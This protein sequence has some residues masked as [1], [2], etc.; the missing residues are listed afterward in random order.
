MGAALKLAHDSARAEKVEQNKGAPRRYELPRVLS[1]ELNGRHKKW[2]KAEL[3]RLRPRR[4][5]WRED[6]AGPLRFA[7]DTL[8]LDLTPEQQEVLA[9]M[10]ALSCGAYRGRFKPYG[11]ALKSGRGPGKTTLGAVLGLWKL[12][13]FDFSLVLGTS[14]KERQLF[15]VLWVK[16]KA[17]ID[18]SVVL[19]GLLDW[20]ATRIGVVGQ[21]EE[22]QA[23][24]RVAGQT[25]NIL[26]AH[27]P[28]FLVLVE[29]SSG[30]EDAKYDAV[31]A[32]LTERDNYIYAVGNTTRNVGWFY[33][34][35]HQDRAYWCTRTFTCRGN[36]L[37]D[38][39]TIER[40]EAQFGRG[41]MEVRVW[42]DGEFP[43][44]SDAAL[45]S[46]A[47]IRNAEDRAPYFDG[48]G[49]L[50][51]GIDPARFGSD[52]TGIVVSSGSDLVHGERVHGLRTTEVVGRVVA[53]ARRM[54]ELERKT[55]E[56]R[57]ERRRAQLHALGRHNDAEAVKV[58]RVYIRNVTCDEIGIGAG[59]VDDLIDAQ[60]IARE[61]REQSFPL[62]SASIVGLN[63][64]LPADDSD[65]F[66]R[67][68]DELWFALS[69]R[70][71][72]GRVAY[73][74]TFDADQRQR[75]AQELRPVEYGYSKTGRKRVDDKDKMRKKLK[76]SPDTADAVIHTFFSTYVGLLD[77]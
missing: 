65:Q 61:N 36:P 74:S 5:R 39:S 69:A 23:V 71:F 45:F 7:R 46:E 75:L 2:G 17:F 33:D 35:F 28:N 67:L 49:A 63:V 32:G 70:Y 66:E 4:V 57:A 25:E 24:A 31:R 30:L 34:A 73:R 51:I 43:E 76:R 8:R 22:W 11:V 60:I 6:P 50:D 72:E 62:E 3:D 68:R 77:V 1:P 41:S 15:D 54:L 13:A 37:V 12:A 29:E 40:T 58:P 19:S 48:G 16:M 26:G 20:T 64:A 52:D 10:G 38:Q 9:T 21:S 53:V 47:W 18:A 56:D 59:V 42:I 14:P 44:Q 55:L 27:R